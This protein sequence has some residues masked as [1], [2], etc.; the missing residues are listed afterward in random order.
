M[1]AKSSSPWQ[2]WKVKGD[3]QTGRWR[4]EPELNQV[5]AD[6][7]TVHLEPKVMQV[8]VCLAG[9]AGEVVSK[10]DI[11]RAVWPD[12][13]V[14]DDVLTRAISELRKALGDAKRPAR[15]I[16]TIPKRGYRLLAPV[17]RADHPEPI[18]SL[19]VLPFVNLNSDPDLEY[20]GDG[21]A[22]CL[23][24][25]LTQLP[26]LSVPARST[27]LRYKGREAAPCEV[28]REL[29]ASA[30]L[31]GTVLLHGDTV[32]VRAELVET[33]SGRQLWGEQYNRAW[34]D[35]LALEEEIGRQISEALRLRLTGE[36]VSK[37]RRRPT[38]DGEAYRLY[39][40]G[41]YLWN[42]RTE[43]AIKSAILLFEEAIARDPEYALAHAGLAD[44]Y[45]VLSCQIDYAAL[46]PAVARPRAE[47]AARRALELDESLAEAHTSLACAF[48]SFHWDWQA[49]EREYRRAI[50]LNPRYATA[51]HWY[52]FLCAALGRMEEARREIQIAHE[53]DP[54]SLAIN[55]D[56]GKI[57]FLERDFEGAIRHLRWTLELEP[58]FFPARALLGMSYAL[59][60]M[61][62]KASAELHRALGLR[63]EDSLPITYLGE[64][65]G[66]VLNP[67][68]EEGI[69]DLERLAER[70]YVPACCWAAVYLQSGD[71]DR[72][73]QYLSK[74]IEERSNWLVYLRVDPIF[75]PLRSD[76][77]FEDL[78]ARV[79][80]PPARGGSGEASQ[81]ESR[82]PRAYV[83]N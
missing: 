11:F 21:I 51:H 17:E 83:S 14:T 68:R 25:L 15:F 12:T 52:A 40:K 53:L 4:V 60:G 7:K 26:Q 74:G 6:G 58:S 32:V 41:R 79:G 43:A 49:A 2:G 16:Q 54:F 45:N 70:R 64:V 27:V 56:L 61:P 50:E 37:L 59:Q 66:S 31:V 63:G 81:P 76:P 3:F 19:A 1:E 65:L 47:A 13:F 62:E 69:Q 39:L 20:L 36:Q 42:R 57:H 30:I 82:A 24:N 38:N 72:A 35:L 34:R 22:S 28:G 77:R 23:I 78:A 9:R 44:C 48:H 33:E 5:I 73:F 18:R 67:K 46:P 80:L 55:T 29:K 8:L 75:D 71:L 10:Q